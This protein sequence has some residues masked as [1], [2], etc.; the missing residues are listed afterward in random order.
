MLAA[1]EGTFAWESHYDLHLITC[2][3]SGVCVIFTAPVSPPCLYDVMV[4]VDFMVQA[5]F[6]TLTCTPFRAAGLLSRTWSLIFSQLLSAHLAFVGASS[7]CLLQLQQMCRDSFHAA[8]SSEQKT[9]D[10]STGFFF[11]SLVR[12]EIGTRIPFLKGYEEIS[13]MY[14]TLWNNSKTHIHSKITQV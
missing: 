3:L 13:F 5:K 12:A 14:R 2:F 9:W 7:T 10:S 1:L 11:L 6:T 4:S 8:E